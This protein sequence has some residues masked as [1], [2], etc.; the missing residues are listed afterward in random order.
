MADAVETI[1]VYKFSNAFAVEL[2]TN[3]QWE[4]K[5]REENTE[6]K[7][8]GKDGYL[9]QKFENLDEEYRERLYRVRVFEATEG[10]ITVQKTT[11]SRSVASYVPKDKKNKN[12]NDLSEEEF[13]QLS[14]S[15]QR[16]YEKFL[17]EENLEREVL[18][19]ELIEVDAELSQDVLIGKVALNNIHQWVKNVRGKERGNYNYNNRDKSYYPNLHNFLPISLNANDVMFIVEQIGETLPNKGFMAKVVYRSLYMT[20]AEINVE[21]FSEVYDGKLRKIYDTKKNGQRYADGRG[22][23]VQDFPMVVGRAKITIEDIDSWIQSVGLN[24]FSDTKKEEI[25]TNFTKSLWKFG[26]V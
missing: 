7:I 13:M 6:I 9:L 12:L 16:L 19:Y 3:L 17:G 15:F 11:R 22:R 20:P 5:T 2:P 26:E 14:E 18:E 4:R 21:F 8:L 25:L 1:K 10:E 23:H 24:T